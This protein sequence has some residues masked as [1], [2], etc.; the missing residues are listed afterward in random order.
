MV[1]I[2]KEIRRHNPDRW[3]LLTYDQYGPHVEDYFALKYLWDNKVLTY[4]PH[5]HSSSYTQPLD[6]SIIM[7]IKN[8]FVTFKRRFVLSTGRKPD[9]YQIPVLAYRAIRTICDVEPKVAG[10]G[11]TYGGG[12]A[13]IEGAFRKTGFYPFNPHFAIDMSHLV[14]LSAA[15]DDGMEVVIQ[16]PPAE[17]TPSVEYKEGDS[18]VLMRRV[19]RGGKD[20]KEIFG[21]ATVLAARKLNLQQLRD[22][23]ILVSVTKVIGRD[24]C[25]V[26]L[27]YADHIQDHLTYGD[28][29]EASK[30]EPFITAHL[31]SLTALATGEEARKARLQKKEEQPETNFGRADL[32]AD[33]VKN[34]IENPKLDEAC[35]SFVEALGVGDGDSPVVSSVIRHIVE[36]GGAFLADFYSSFSQIHN[37]KAKESGGGD[38]DDDNEQDG[39]REIT[40]LRGS[41]SINAYGESKS[42]PKIGNLGGADGGRLS[43]MREVDDMRGQAQEASGHHLQSRGARLLPVLEALTSAGLVTRDFNHRPKMELLEAYV[44]REPS[45]TLAFQKYKRAWKLQGSTVKYEFWFDFIYGGGVNHATVV[46]PEGAVPTPL[47][48]SSAML[49]KGT[50][51]GFVPV[52][53]SGPIVAV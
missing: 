35:D 19:R 8:L 24:R 36:K 4:S 21:W 22:D 12:K 14:A 2:V 28:A 23:E 48:V 42:L 1:H 10:G 46:G 20:V 40:A 29:M 15:T 39:H 17:E 53:P 3:V 31:Q 44:I 45:R 37:G 27:L 13:L 7:P 49:N 32:T 43:H 30:G 25:S 47:A 11:A 6:V 26:R 41:R 16:P 34:I 51:T 18:V 38:A 5:S 50:T 9:Q 33:V 52:V